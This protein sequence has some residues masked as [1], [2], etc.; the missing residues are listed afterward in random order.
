MT[1]KFCS[2]VE[3]DAIDGD[4][5]SDFSIGDLGIEDSVRE[6][7]RIWRTQKHDEIVTHSVKRLHGNLADMT[8]ALKT[9]LKESETGCTVVEA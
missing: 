5:M 3:K 1:L 9:R 8:R 7:C 4:G 6:R 2:R